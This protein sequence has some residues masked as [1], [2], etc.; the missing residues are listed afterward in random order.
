M[1]CFVQPLPITS[2]RGHINRPIRHQ[3]VERAEPGFLQSAKIQCYI[4]PPACHS[5]Y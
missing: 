2:G 3:Y 4:Y 5:S 1:R